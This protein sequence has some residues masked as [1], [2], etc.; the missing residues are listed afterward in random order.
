MW[1]RIKNYLLTGLILSM[2]SCMHEEKQQALE[3]E[4]PSVAP[5]E[6]DKPV[7][8]SFKVEVQNQKH[9][10]K[11]TPATYVSGYLFRLISEDIYYYWKGTP[12]DFN[13]TKQV[14]QKGSIACGY[15]VTN[16][17]SDLG[18]RIQRIRLAMAPSSEMIKKLCTDIRKFTEFAE[19]QNYIAGQPAKSVLI[20]GLDYH[21]GYILKDS[22]QSYFLHSNYVNRKGVI[23]EK[24]ENSAVLKNNK[25]FMIG[26]L[27]GNHI[28]LEKWI[29][30]E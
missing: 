20:V 27:T 19:L 13:G 1:M 21:T 5:V 28:I 11:D 22:V 24:I 8:D 29:S 6:I 18:F 17:L 30:D 12:W 10:L 14:P 23:K 9:Y 16:T 25:T 26:S 2:I 4:V 15:F 7:Y 3:F